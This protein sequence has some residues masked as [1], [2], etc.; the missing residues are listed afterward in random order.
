[1]VRVVYSDAGG[2]GRGMYDLVSFLAPDQ[3][4]TPLEALIQKEERLEAYRR[5]WFE[6]RL[7]EKWQA[8]RKKNIR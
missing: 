1:M 8:F 7:I 4:P 6:D 2:D 3:P 5:W